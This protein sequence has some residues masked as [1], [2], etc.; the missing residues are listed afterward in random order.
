MIYLL[1]IRRKTRFV[2]FTAL[3]VLILYLIIHSIFDINSS[4][5]S[6]NEQIICEITPEMRIKISETLTTVVNEILETL[7]MTYFL[8][9]DS[10]WGALGV[11]GP[12][13]WHQ[14]VD[15]CLLNEEVERFEEAFLIRVFRRKG[16]SLSYQTS[17][18]IYLVRPEGDSKPTLRLYLFEQSNGNYRRVG[19]KNRLVPPDSCELVHCFPT[20]LISKPLPTE[21]FMSM[22]LPVPREGIELQKYLFPDNWWLDSQ[23]EECK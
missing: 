16:L 4:K 2:L 14:R 15:I 21:K 22:R 11:N 5:F 8:C 7:D 20:R 12:L 13:K 6:S 10:L 17:D 18:G 1:K 3:I 19:W 23:P 9:Y